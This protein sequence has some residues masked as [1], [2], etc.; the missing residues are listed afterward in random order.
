M[1]IAFV[2][3]KENANAS[4]GTA[5]TMTYAAVNGNAVLLGVQF[6]AAIAGPTCVDNNAH[7]L[8]NLITNGNERVFVGVASAG[9]TGYTL[10]W[11]NA[12]KYAA[13]LGEYSGN[14]PTAPIGAAAIATATSTTPS[15][16][17]TTQDNG[18]WLIAFFGGGA[19]LT[20]TASLGTIRSQITGGAAATSMCLVDNPAPIPNNSQVTATA[21]QLNN[22]WFAAGLELFPPQAG[23]GSLTNWL[24]K[25]KASGA[26]KHGY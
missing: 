4:T 12:V 16:G 9:V 6:S 1:A 2:G 18:S 19:N 13:C 5:A 10:S 8:A 14:N 25:S 17:L 11:T 3:K 21:L 15:I 26:N 7:P 22:Q 24:S 23:G 20:Y